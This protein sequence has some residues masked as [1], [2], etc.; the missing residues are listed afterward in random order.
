M[1]ISPDL[2]N[3]FKIGNITIN[4]TVFYTWIIMLILV[5]GSILSTRRLSIGKKISR[6]QNF[7][8]TLIG[9]MRKEIG[10]ITRLDPDPLIPF[11]GTLFIFISFSSILS[12]FPYYNPPTGSILTTASLSIC[13]FFAVHV[14]GITHRGLANYFKRYI[15][16]NILMLPFN[17]LSELSR[18]LALAVRL[19]GNVM[20]GTMIA[21]V[22]LSIAP[23]F[24][25]II[26]QLFGL[27]I[28]QIQAYI[29]AILATVYI[30]S[31]MQ[32]N[33]KK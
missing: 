24:F 26:I 11:I 27:L 5:I 4:A 31:G 33:N 15:K 12:I 25:P 8:E 19:F 28:G 17:V 3:F 10:E 32:S 1:K 16:P 29:F 7:L 2:I 6:W 30:S 21:G 18:T 23:F 14:F 20:S 13:V 9:Y 22:L